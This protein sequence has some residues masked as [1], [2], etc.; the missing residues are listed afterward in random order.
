MEKKQNVRVTLRESVKESHLAAQDESNRSHAGKR[1]TDDGS[2]GLSN[3]CKYKEIGQIDGL[4]MEANGGSVS[5]HNVIDSLFHI[6]III[7]M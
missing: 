2:Y 7:V 3:S 6:I 5:C 1:R 4:N